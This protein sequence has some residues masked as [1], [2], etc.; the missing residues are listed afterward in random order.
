MPRLL[1]GLLA[2]TLLTGFPAAAQ[3]TFSPG[4]F[5]ND[6]P[7]LKVGVVADGIYY[8]TGAD[9]Q[10]AGF[11]LG[12][13]RVERIAL[14]ENGREVPLLVL[15]GRGQTLASTDTL[16][17]A[18]R[19]NTGADE[20]WA[21]DAPSSQSSPYYSLF[22]D[23]TYYW[24]HVGE[25]PGL[26]Y[27]PLAAPASLPAP[28]QSARDTVH[29]E[30]ETIA[31]DGDSNDS[32]HPLYTRGEAKYHHRFFL[33][34]ATTQ[35][36]T[37]LLKLPG[38]LRQDS[39]TVRARLSAGSASRH[40]VSLL[41]EQYVGSSLQF[42][43]EAEADWNGYAFRDLHATL[44]GLDVVANGD[45]RVR[46]RH[47]NSFGGNPNIVFVD[48]FEVGYERQL[49]P[50]GGQDRFVLDAGAVHLRLGGYEGGEAFALVPALA[51][52]ARKTARADSLAIA[53][54]LP[55]SARVFTARRDALRR[56]ARTARVERPA[57][58]GHAGADY[59]IVTTPALR[60]SAEALAAEKQARQG[61]RPLVVLQ[62]DLFDQFDYGRPTPLAVRRFLYQTRDWPIVP[63]FFA[64]WGDALTAS[65][66]RPLQPW[67]VITYGNAPS[68]SWFGMQYGGPNDWSEVAAIG[69]IPLRTNA[70]GE[71]FVA[72]LRAYAEAPVGAWQRRSLQGSGGYTPL[73]VTSLANA[74]LGWAQIS[75]QSA[76]R[77]DTSLIVKRDLEKVSASWRDRI[78]AE[79]QQGVSWFTFFG[80]SSPQLWEIVTDAPNVM[81]NA[82][83]LPFISSFGCRT[84]NFTIGSATEHTLSLAEQMVTGSPHGGIAHWGSSELSSIGVGT[85]LGNELHRA[86][87]VDSIRVMG[88]AARLAKAQYAAGPSPSVKNLLQYGLLGDPA[89]ELR[90]PTRPNVHVA[91]ADVRFSTDT[92]VVADSTLDVFV[93]VRNFGLMLRDSVDVQLEHLPANGTSA[94]W[95]QRV[96]PFADSVRITFQVPLRGGEVGLHRF[97]VL[98]DP[99]GRIAEE[100][101]TDNAVTRELPV[102]SSGLALVTPPDLSFLDEART[103]RATRSSLATTETTFTFELDTTAT[104]DSPFRQTHTATGTTLAE[105]TLSAPLAP[106]QPYFWRVR[107]DESGGAAPWA[108]ATF[109]LRPDLGTDGWFADGGTA[110]LALS[111]GLTRTADGWRFAARPLSATLTSERGSGFYL[112]AISAGNEE[113][114]A[115]TLGWGFVV[116]DGVTGEVKAALAIPTY[117]M[118][119]SLEERFNTNETIARARLDSLAR[120][121][122]PGDLVLGRSRF[123]G[124]SSGPTIQ[125][126]VKAN[127]RALG[128]TAV[129]TMT[130]GHLWQM[131]A[132]VGYPD[133]RWERVVAPGGTNEVLFD[134]TFTVRSRSGRI[135]SPAIGPALSWETLGIDLTSGDAYATLDV[136]DAAT[137]SVLAR[138]D[139][140]GRQTFS[141]SSIDAA[142]HPRLRLGLTL[143][144][145]SAYQPGRDDAGRTPAP[146]LGALYVTHAPVTDLLLDGSA[147]VAAATV[148]EGEALTVAVPVRNLGRSPAPQTVVSYFLVDAQNRE[149]LVARDTL[150]TLAA[151]QTDTSRVVLATTGRVGQNQLRA[152]A[153]Q[154]A[155]E[156]ILLNNFYQHRFTVGGDAVPPTY[157]ILIDGE[158]FPSAGPLTNLQDPS[159]PFVS[160]RPT[161]EITVE[162]ENAFRP[163]DDS[164][165]VQLTLNGQRIGLNDPDVQFTPATAGQRQARLV[166]TPDLSGRDT[167]YTLVLRAFDTSGNEAAGSPYQV[168]FR[169]QNALLV[170]SVLPYPNPMNTHTTF[171]FRVKGADAS[172][173]EE[174]RLRIYTL[175]GQLVREFDL[176]EDPSGLDAGGLRIGWNKLRWDGTDADGD[177]LATGV[178]LYRVFMRG[179]GQTLGSSDVERIAI[180]R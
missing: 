177:R 179:E 131:V 71:Q 135:T 83:L 152:R 144:D 155:P 139:A 136:R 76:A 169:V 23:T 141:L 110:R 93:T 111:D 62:S 119:A 158:A 64:F 30:N 137:D 31:Y 77:Q 160:A 65:R 147:A 130:Y 85:V 52:F 44:A 90:L 55:A 11:S 154:Q 34:S 96:A 174:C 49:A 48:F 47:D 8:L 106:G 61:L 15:G 99:A 162:D 122:E 67:E 129:D 66:E 118:A 38:L 86:V 146:T 58:A 53:A 4:W 81:R 51:G 75:A 100:D 95:S 20:A 114:L 104:F 19:R 78:T 94:R 115:L 1:L 164:T 79:F 103:L 145:S 102:L 39:V 132:R 13:W 84:G 45:F 36:A 27:E 157:A 112:G 98:A 168:H 56:P 107:T 5:S 109:T 26:R 166:Y 176:I 43:P 148:A 123:L 60:A 54:T 40:R 69:R 16:V 74:T 24:L 105:W 46:L 128:S 133:Q 153:E 126:D 178:Y 17:F 156:P 142:Q 175:T 91:A 80:H 21:Y 37:F 29:V 57:L 70:E 116:L 73:E 140:E 87:F 121:A 82:P 138:Y 167:T 59:V 163:L 165:V 101:E 2:L 89:V 7:Y 97:G 161:I 180:I 41:A 72:K 108:A 117:R 14:I 10:A 173:I 113:F 18:G 172:G 159:F 88:E 171:A 32:G 6:R 50:T 25:A 9:V 151:G 92:P 12:A 42:I 33:T 35:E 170:E 63:R 125:D 143:T 134:T 149:Q 124:N 150:G 127:L 28:R 120:A 22:S 68:D 3:P